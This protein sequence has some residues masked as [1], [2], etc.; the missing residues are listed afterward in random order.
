MFFTLFYVRTVVIL[1]E[2]QYALLKSETIC[3]FFLDIITLNNNQTVYNYALTG[4]FE[5]RFITFA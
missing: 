1:I 4:L 2:K 3:K 5:G